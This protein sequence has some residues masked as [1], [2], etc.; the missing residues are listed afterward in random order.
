M[1]A[2]EPLPIIHSILIDNHTSTSCRR[3][4][5][6]Q[7][8]CEDRDCIE[9][10]GVFVDLTSIWSM[11]LPPILA[12][13]VLGLLPKKTNNDLTNFGNI[14]PGDIDWQY[15][16]NRNRKYSLE[17]DFVKII[18]NIIGLVGRNG[19]SLVSR[20]FLGANH[21]RIG[22][23]MNHRRCLLQVSNNE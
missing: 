2:I 6:F 18:T 19:E 22:Q 17:V 21:G 13:V 4:R 7:L 8:R 16:H 1:Y 5:K 3:R 9:C 20:F 10:A 14:S 11:Y 12:R 15:L 23:E